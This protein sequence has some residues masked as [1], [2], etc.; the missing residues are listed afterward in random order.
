MAEVRCHS[1]FTKRFLTALVQLTEKAIKKAIKRRFDYMKEHR[2]CAQPSSA[3]SAQQGPF[4]CSRHLL[5]PA[6]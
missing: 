6:T 1:L 5:P 4:R 3:S 2:K